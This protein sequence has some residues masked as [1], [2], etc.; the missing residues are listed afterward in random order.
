MY[1]QPNVQCWALWRVDAG[2]TQAE[3]RES[4]ESIYMHINA[5]RLHK[6][7]S[8]FLFFERQALSPIS[9]EFQFGQV[10]HNVS[11]LSIFYIFKS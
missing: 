11:W 7:K 4:W 10:P 6:P 8:F 5:A 2:G 3:I 9:F 1:L